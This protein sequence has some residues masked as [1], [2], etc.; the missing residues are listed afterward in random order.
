MAIAPKKNIVTKVAGAAVKAV[1]KSSKPSLKAAQKAKPLANPKSAVKVKSPAKTK[2]APANIAKVNYKNSDSAYRNAR[3][4]DRQYEKDAGT[5]Y[6]PYEAQYIR[7]EA[8][9]DARYQ[10]KAL[11]SGKKISTA[12]ENKATTPR[13]TKDIV[14]SNPWVERKKINSAVKSAPKNKATVR[15]L[16]AANKKK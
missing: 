4:A 5:M 11:I 9:A 1:I 2:P 14:N 6:N 15:G 13:A 10:R 7:G 16:K 3:Q 12:N 8:A